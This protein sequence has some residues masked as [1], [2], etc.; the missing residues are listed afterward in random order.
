MSLSPVAPVLS[1]KLSLPVTF[2]N[3]CVGKEVDD[4]LQN[5]TDGQIVLLENVR[6]H[7]GETENDPEFARQLASHADVFVNDAFGTAHRAHASTFGVARVYCHVKV[8]G[9]L[10]AKELEF[11]GQR[12]QLLLTVHLL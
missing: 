8:S 10:I 3:D 6:F 7:K 11:L 1:E 9:Y 2:I 5:I 12:K 4:A